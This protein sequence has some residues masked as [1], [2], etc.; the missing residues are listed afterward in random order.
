MGQDFSLR[1][2]LIDPQGNFG[3]I[4]DPPAAMR[5]TECRMD[6]LAAV[7]L[8]GID[9]NTVD[10]V[11]NY[12]GTEQQPAVLPA[13]FPNLLVNGSQGIAVGMATNMPPYNLG[14]IVEAC[15]FGLENPDAGPEEYL[16][17]V[18]GP[19]FPTGAYIVGT[20]GAKDAMVSGRGSVKIRAVTDVEEIRPVRPPDGSAVLLRIPVRR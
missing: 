17:I 8:D 10:F 19:D 2:P 3:T 11:D 15:L 1:Y 13:R 6:Q 14:E 4:D 12:D 9:E 5:Y 16:K 18:K 20:K 7:L